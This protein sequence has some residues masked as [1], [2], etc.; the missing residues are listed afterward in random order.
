MKLP[1]AIALALLLLAAQLAPAPPA[2][3]VAEWC[4]DDPLITIVTPH[5]NQVL[6]HVTNYGQ[7]PQALLEVKQAR[8]MLG[9]VGSSHDEQLTGVKLRVLIQHH[10]GQRFNT[11]S[12]V[13][14][15][16]SGSGVVLARVDGRSGETM[17][18]EFKLD[19]P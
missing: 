17:E 6:L 4:E 1:C 9:E 5:G 11:R 8:I 13:S 12:V 15:G 16:P 7:D 3:A 18:L 10:L 2:G 19:V 14:T